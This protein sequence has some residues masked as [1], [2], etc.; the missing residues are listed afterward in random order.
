MLVMRGLVSSGQSLWTGSLIAALSSLMDI[1]VRSVGAPGE[2]GR[3]RKS[4]LDLSR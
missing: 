2:G 1:E 4:D 3:K